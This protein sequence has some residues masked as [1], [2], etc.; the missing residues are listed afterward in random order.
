M[1]VTEEWYDLEKELR[2]VLLSPQQGR[3]GGNTEALPGHT[4]SGVARESPRFSLTVR[5]KESLL[6]LKVIPKDWDVRWAW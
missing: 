5:I 1:R 2:F 6:S 3:G 4:G